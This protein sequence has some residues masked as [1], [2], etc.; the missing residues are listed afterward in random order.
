MATPWDRLYSCSAGQ[1]GAPEVQPASPRT[2]ETPQ[3]F[4]LRR[5]LPFPAATLLLICQSVAYIVSP[6]ENVS[7]R[8]ICLFSSVQQL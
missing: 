1:I 3:T 6:I 4:A 5:A 2:V 8:T 7:N